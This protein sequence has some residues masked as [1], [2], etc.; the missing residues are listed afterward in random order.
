MSS[1]WSCV[2]LLTLECIHCC[3]SASSEITDRWCVTLSTWLQSLHGGQLCL[4][5]L[6]PSLSTHNVASLVVYIYR[7]C[8]IP[9][10]IEDFSFTSVFS[11]LSTCPV[12]LHDTN[13]S[14]SCSCCYLW[15]YLWMNE[16]VGSFQIWVI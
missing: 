1:A 16:C 3:L 10:Q 13:F 14:V 5:W 11:C 6:L 9:D 2:L 7:P 8:H 12:A 4:E 15:M